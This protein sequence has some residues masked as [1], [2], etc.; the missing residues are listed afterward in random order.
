MMINVPHASAIHG[1]P[2][3][4]SSLTR[5]LD[6]ANTRLYTRDRHC[7]PAAQ[8]PD[9]NMQ[10]KKLA[11]GNKKGRMIAAFSTNPLFRLVYATFLFESKNCSSSVEPCSA[12]VD[13]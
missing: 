10:T 8:V 7:F 12:V 2:G 9:G 5:N 13:D 1:T 6:G 3:C 4:V 11:K